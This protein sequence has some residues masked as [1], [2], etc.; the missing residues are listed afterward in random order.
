MAKV[1]QL[2]QYTA[3]SIAVVEF[4]KKNAKVFDKYNELLIEASKAE[5]ELKSY[6]KDKVKGNLGNDF[7][8]VTYVPAYSKY[9]DPATVLE[10]ATPKVKKELM[11][12]G[13][14]VIEQKVDSKKFVELVERGVVPVAIQQK[15]FREKELSPRVIIKE[16]K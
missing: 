3:A 10:M 11:A 7:V 5:S 2:E 14:I 16:N 13:A 8:K 9:Y 15:A 1:K 4:K 12:E 6:V